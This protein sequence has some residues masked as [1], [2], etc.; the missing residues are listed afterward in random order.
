MSGLRQTSPYVPAGGTMKAL[1]LKYC[2][3]VSVMIGPVNA[4]FQDGRIGLRL[5][6]LFVGLKPN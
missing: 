2:C 6:P 4:G 3:G 1:G 5:S